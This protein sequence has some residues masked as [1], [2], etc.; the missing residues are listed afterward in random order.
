MLLLAFRNKY[1]LVT[2]QLI[3]FIFNRMPPL[4]YK[5]HKCNIQFYF[6]FILFKVYILT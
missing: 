3:Y 5:T 2:N 4:T 1:A 6:Y